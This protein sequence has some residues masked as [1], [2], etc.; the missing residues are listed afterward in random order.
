LELPFSNLLGL[1]IAEAE[2]RDPLRLVAV[3]TSQKNI[4]TFDR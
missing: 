2:R 1:I 3:A 4:V